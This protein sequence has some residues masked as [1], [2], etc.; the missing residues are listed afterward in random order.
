MEF[1]MDGKKGKTVK[2]YGS[3]F[4]D[5]SVAR[6]GLSDTLNRV[7]YGKERIVIR[8]HGKEIA[9]LVP[10]EDLAFLEELEDRLDLEEARASDPCPVTGS[11][12]FRQPPGSWVPFP[13]SSR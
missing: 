12:W 10:M 2:P 1:R 7:S 3:G 9:A 6:D 8:R 5:T 13:K 11:N 4:I